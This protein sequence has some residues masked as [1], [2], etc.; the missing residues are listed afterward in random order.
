MYTIIL[1]YKSHRE[2]Q[3]ASSLFSGHYMADK[4]SHIPGV[5]SIDVVN[6][7]TGEVGYYIEQ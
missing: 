4:F 5:Q 2:Y 7:K 6:D 1:N 3:N